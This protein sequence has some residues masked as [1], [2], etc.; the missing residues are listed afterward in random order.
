MVNADKVALWV[1]LLMLII[2]VLLVEINVKF[3]FQLRYALNVLI[4]MFVIIIPVLKAVN[5]F[6][7][8]HKD[9]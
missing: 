9:M 8:P 3:V 7:Q 4:L 2:H 6:S 1:I 5:C